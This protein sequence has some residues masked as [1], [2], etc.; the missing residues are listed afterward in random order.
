MRKVKQV[1]QKEIGRIKLTYRQEFVASLVDGERLDLTVWVNSN[2]YKE[3]TK[4]GLR[5]YV[6]EEIEGI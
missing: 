5:L 2:N 1:K 3:W 4:Q 6:L